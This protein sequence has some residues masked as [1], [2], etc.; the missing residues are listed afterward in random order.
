MKKESLFKVLDKAKEKQ[1]AVLLI[2]DYGIGKSQLI[3][4]YA[5]QKAMELNKKLVIW[6]QLSEDEKKRLVESESL[7]DYFIVVDLKL[8][9]IGDISK[10]TGIPIILNNGNE[11]KVFWE[12]PSF[13]KVLTK[14][15][16]DGILFLDEI[17]M[18]LPSLQSTCFE[19]LLQKKVGEWKLNENILIVGAGNTLE[20]NVSA[21]PIP[22]PLINR[23]ILV[24]F[25][26]FDT[27]DWIEWA[28]KKGIDERVISYVKL[29]RE[30][31][32]NDEEELRQSTRP[33]SFEILSDM[34]KDVDNDLEYIETV[35]FGCLHQDDAIQF[36]NFIKLMDKLDY[37]KYI[38]EPTLFDKEEAQIK[39]ALITIISKNI[40]N[41]DKD[42]LVKF[43]THISTKD[44][45]FSLL[46]LSLLKSKKSQ[47]LDKVL[48]KLPKEIIERFINILT[49]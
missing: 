34:I 5:E 36:I 35:A 32:K 39:Y 21:N 10:I 4:S 44:A 40:E 6:H 43:I 13:L 12:L 49:W 30:L 14:K 19:L 22:K 2:G 24:H 45:E 28:L 41:I 38:D 31:I 25:Y 1:K 15:E 17:N 37:K 9:T 33:R 7:K 20:S 26:G 23:C 29:F 47:V 48:E 46:L 8:Q 27:E 3:Y 42:K 11:H 16:V 18:A